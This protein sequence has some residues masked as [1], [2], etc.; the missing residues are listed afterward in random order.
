VTKTTSASIT[1]DEEEPE[2]QAKHEEP[3]LGVNF[4]SEG[5]VVESM[6]IDVSLNICLPQV[7]DNFAL[8]GFESL[9]NI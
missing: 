4:K 1:A 6:D 8:Q 3:Q 5:E 2:D 9:E 7:E